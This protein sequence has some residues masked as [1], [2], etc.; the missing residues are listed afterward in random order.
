MQSPAL[1]HKLWDRIFPNKWVLGLFLVLLFGIPRFILVL[2]S[3]IRGQSEFVSIVFTIMWFTPL[4]F[5]KKTG[6][7]EIGLHKSTHPWWLLWGFLLGCGMCVLLFAFT[8]LLYGLEIS[9]PFVY[10]ASLADTDNGSGI[11]F[12]IYMIIVMTFSP[13][14]EE[15]FYRGVVHHAFRE[16]FGE[17]KASVIDSAAFALTHLA[18]FGIVYTAG[19]FKL[20]PLPALIW[21]LSMFFTCMVFNQVRR[22]SGSILGAIL[23]HAG[24]NFAMGFLIF[25]AL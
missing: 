17:R 20:L 23:T 4:I 18:H 25:Y 13:I 7:R 5:L 2:D 9:N 24:F 3:F 14:G 12:L 16:R 11:Y 10:I 6:R 19:G 8:R 15:L 21:V 22:E 1:Y